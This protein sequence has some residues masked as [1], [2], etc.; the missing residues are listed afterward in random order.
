MK[1][2]SKEEIKELM[3]RLKH[4]GGRASALNKDILDL[5]N[6]IKV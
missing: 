6:K 2:L 1:K 5:L 3:P 4:K